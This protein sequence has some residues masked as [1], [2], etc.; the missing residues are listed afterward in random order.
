[1]KGREA[2][3]FIMD[4]AEFRKKLVYLEFKGKIISWKELI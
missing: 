3:Y 4:Y 2:D 1:M